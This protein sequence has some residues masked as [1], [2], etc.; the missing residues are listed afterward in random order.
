[1]VSKFKYFPQKSIC[2]LIYWFSCQATMNKKRVLY[3]V[4]IISEPAGLKISLGM[5][6]REKILW[7]K[8]VLRIH[9]DS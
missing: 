3:I 5:N 7:N 6:E 8:I 2:L 4:C 1:M 9:Y